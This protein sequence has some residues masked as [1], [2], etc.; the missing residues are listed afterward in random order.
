M[1]RISD[2]LFLIAPYI[3]FFT[4]NT[5]IKRLAVVFRLNPLGA[6]SWLDLRGRVPEGE[7]R[8]GKGR[9]TPLLQTDRR[10]VAWYIE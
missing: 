10:P 1:R 6:H 4:Y 8:E 9:N 3:N 7:G 2:F 5:Y